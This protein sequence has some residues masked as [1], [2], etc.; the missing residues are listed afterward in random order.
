MSLLS[1]CKCLNSSSKSTFLLLQFPPEVMP[2]LYIA[3]ESLLHCAL[4]ILLSSAVFLGFFVPPTIPSPCSAPTRLRLRFRL[5]AYR[6]ITGSEGSSDGFL[7]VDTVRHLWLT[8]RTSISGITSL[9]RFVFRFGSL[10]RSGITF[11]QGQATRFSV[12]GSVTLSPWLFLV[13]ALV[14]TTFSAWFARGGS[15]LTFISTSPQCIR[16]THRVRRYVTGTPFTLRILAPVPTST[17][18]FSQSK[19][20]QGQGH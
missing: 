4:L 15:G 20:D 5:F 17:F 12:G 8:V 19:V 10:A 11:L 2:I 7:V 6:R 3:P 13:F 9:A 18:S 16:T 14:A 1:Q